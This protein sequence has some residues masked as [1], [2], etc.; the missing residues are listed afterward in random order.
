[1]STTGDG[2]VP[3]SDAPVVPGVASLPPAE[4]GIKN[5][6]VV[7]TPSSC[8]PVPVPDDAGN[9][10]TL[11]LRGAVVA[12]PGCPGEAPLPN[13]PLRGGSYSGVT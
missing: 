11:P 7:F 9:S 5:E 12:E 6:P 8:P 1:L 2:V 3:E 13:G 10:G 4:E